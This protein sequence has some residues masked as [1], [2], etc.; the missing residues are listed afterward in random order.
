MPSP[1]VAPNRRPYA[2][3]K[4]VALHEM[5]PAMTFAGSGI[6]AMLHPFTSEDIGIVLKSAGIDL[7][8]E[9]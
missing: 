5:T 1:F 3:T 4:I 6:V 2:R 9:R 8:E 7:R